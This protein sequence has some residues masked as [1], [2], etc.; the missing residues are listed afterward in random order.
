MKAAHVNL[1]HP[2]LTITAV[3]LTS[4]PNSGPNKVH[5]FSVKSSQTHVFKMPA[6]FTS[7][8]L[9]AAIINTILVISL[10]TTLDTYCI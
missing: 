7:A 8:L 5:T 1:A 6:D 2:S 4:L 3:L 10:E 9:S